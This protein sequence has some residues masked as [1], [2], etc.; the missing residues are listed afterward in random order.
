MTLK[1]RVERVHNQDS[2]V[3]LLREG[4]GWPVDPEFAF[5]EVP[6]IAAGVKSDS[7]VTVSQLVP[8]TAEDKHLIVLAE[9]EKP[10]VRRDLLELLR[11]LRS[12][13]RATGKFQ[14]YTGIG[15]TLF[16]VAAPDYEDVRFVLFEDRERRKARIRSFGWRREF[17]GRTV[18]THNLERLK[19]QEDPTARAAAWERAWD[20]EGLTEDFYRD[21]ESV[22]REVLARVQGAPDDKTRHSWTQLLFNRLLFIAFIQRMGWLESPLPRS[23]SSLRE[24]VGGGSSAGGYLFDLWARHAS[25]PEP[26]REYAK[27]GKHVHPKTFK[28]LLD[29]LFFSGLDAPNGIGG[30]DT[31]HPLVGVVPYLNGGLFTRDPILDRSQI[32][33][34][35]E[36]F[37]AVLAEPDGLFA[38]YNFTVT[39]STPL[40]QEVAVDPE[41]LGKIFERLIIQQ[42]RHQS[43]TYYT[44]RPIVEFMVNEALKGYLV[45]RGLPAEKAAMLVDEDRVESDE[46]NFKPSELQDA[47]DWLFEVRAVDPACGSGAYLLMLLQ[48]LFELV[49]RLEVSRDKRR[50]P[51]QKHLYETKLR[52]LQ[53]CVY[54]VDMNETAVRIA[55]LR[56]WL[57]L[58]VEN[59]GEKPEPLPNF[60]FL[61]MQGDSLASPLFPA[62]NVLGYPENEIREYTRMKHR[63]FHPSEGE[64]RP[65][66][67][68]MKAQRTLI[69]DAFAD[70][71]S[72][73]KLRSL[74]PIPF[75]WEVEFAEVFDPHDSEETVGG[76]LNLGMEGAAKGQGELASRSRRAPG[77]DIVLAN[78]PY[79]RYQTLSPIRPGLRERFPAV[80]DGAADLFCYFYGLAIELLSPGGQLAFISSN[81][82]FRSEYGEPLRKFLE[83]TVGIGQIVDFGELPVFQG[84]A[85]FPVVVVGAKGRARLPRLTLVKSLGDPYPDVARLVQ[86]YGYEIASV[87]M[88][89]GEWLLCPEEE[90]KRVL[91]M[92]AKHPTL[93]QYNERLGNLGPKSG[94]KTGYNEAYFVD[95]QV[96][97]SLRQIQGG[98]GFVKALLVGD[99]CRKWRQSFP[100]RFSIVIPRGTKLREDHPIL[101]HLS[102][103]RPRLDNR[104][105][106][107]DSWYD[108]RSCTYLNEA[109]GETLVF[110]DIGREP[111][112]TIKPSGMIPDYTVFIIAPADRYLLG[113]LNSSTAWFYFRLT[114]PVLGDAD[115]GGRLRLQ[116][117]FVSRLPIPAAS[118]TDRSAI[119]SLAQR[120]LDAKAADP[121]AD[122][123]DLEAEIDARVE[124]LYFRRGERGTRQKESG[125]EASYPDTYDEWLALQEAEKGTV[126]EEVRA[127]IAADES[128]IVELKETLEYADRVP[129]NIPETQRDQ[130]IANKRKECVEGV[131]KAIAGFYNAKGGALLIGVHDRS[132][133]IVGL[134]PDFSMCGDKPNRDGFE[135]KL[136]RFLKRIEPLP[137]DLEIYFPEIDGKTVCLI[138]VQPSGVPHW[139]DNR[140][141]VRFG[142]SIEELTGRD[143]EDWLAKRSPIVPDRSSA[144]NPPG[145]NQHGTDSDAPVPFD[146]DP[147]PRLVSGD[148]RN[149]TFQISP[150]ALDQRT[151]PEKPP[152][153]AI[154]YFAPHPERIVGLREASVETAKRE[155]KAITMRRL[156]PVRS[157][158]G[159]RKAYQ[160][161]GLEEPRA[162][163]STKRKA[164]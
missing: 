133:E 42:E 69:S 111:R 109:L 163:T 61:I 59:K 45:E 30:G 71:L 11:S 67:E 43:G 156:D 28:D 60:D 40:D 88:R 19:W 142:N 97:A 3:E 107:G 13:M 77:F 68:E 44:P 56:L 12:H 145:A 157:R 54:G 96:A 17:V 2:L 95:G 125:E 129:A 85:T 63:Y 101:R 105:A 4:L 29:L 23:G 37:A 153:E 53:R 78:P 103:F 21:Y 48:R 135:N 9:F 25:L 149:G 164:D 7:A 73:S 138:K 155:G 161:E 58:V 51:G 66:R 121:N 136:G 62:Q 106:R 139:L 102:N 55:R 6:E 119:E 15:D 147:S 41:M 22:F 20:V 130:W 49:D 116:A 36:A 5:S 87:A 27:L 146:Q 160:F 144:Q 143:I 64:Q 126:V 33:V 140:L 91:H 131:L 72:S 98:E 151:R 123:S 132:K 89:E 31:L 14:G 80:Y 26:A 10:Y 16:I 94:V 127:L 52:L 38:R 39:E 83:K 134:G 65:T 128:L 75:D 34:P 50:N 24:G 120:I 152:E 74:S 108:Y 115:D 47:L 35:D 8:A 79:V 150:H 1:Q 154:A 76:R 124:F 18:L 114:C 90:A 148:A 159:W 113:I 110:P 122:V 117:A 100:E 46:L 162:S 81:K 82:W 93:A 137:S 141:F 32:T 112:F 92:R 158:D 86:D 99:D 104:D 118:T 84:V 70:E 57:S